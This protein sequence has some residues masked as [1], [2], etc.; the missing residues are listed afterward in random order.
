[1]HT[2][3]RTFHNALGENKGLAIYFKD[4]QEL[5]DL[6]DIGRS[7]VKAEDEY[8]RKRGYASDL[9]DFFDLLDK[10]YRETGH[11]DYRYCY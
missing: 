3:I 7:I 9:S 11:G 8:F 6:L 4:R 10:T 5:D 1:M 2:K